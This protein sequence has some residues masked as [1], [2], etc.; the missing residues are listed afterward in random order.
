MPTTTP[1]RP[2]EP[3]PWRTLVAIFAVLVL[4]LMLAQ[5]YEPGLERWREHTQIRI[6]QTV[7]DAIDR[8]RQLDHEWSQR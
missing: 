1:P 2:R 7:D 6:Q 8:L 4:L 3:F 5:R